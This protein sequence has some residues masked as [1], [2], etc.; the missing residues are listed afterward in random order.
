MAA[1]IA[2]TALAGVA[3]GAPHPAANIL[4]GPVPYTCTTRPT[5]PL[6]ENAMIH[7][8]DAARAAT[9]LGP[10]QLPRDFT[11]LTPDRQLL[12]LVNLDRSAYSVI[13]VHGLSSELD[14]AAQESVRSDTDPSAPN[15]FAAGVRGVAANWATGTNLL[16][17]YY[18]WMYE[19]GYPGGNVDCKAPSSSGCWGHRQNILSSGAE[20][21]FHDSGE[22]QERLVS[23]GVGSGWD[24]SGGQIYTL[25]V[26]HSASEAPAYYTWT[27]AMADGAGTFAYDPGPLQ[28]AVRLT[29]SLNGTGRGVV[30]SFQRLCA[31]TCSLSTGTG[32]TFELTATPSRGSVFVGWSGACSGTDACRLPAESDEAVT[33]TFARL[34]APRARLSAATISSRSRSARF[35]FGAQGD[36][37]AFQ[38]ALVRNP[39]GARGPWGRPRFSACRPPKTYTRLAP[40][41]YRFYV[42]ASGPGGVGGPA[43]RQFEIR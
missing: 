12:I 23:I 28:L 41:S 10:Y 11:A 4:M 30:S 24:S 3:V 35:G 15:E 9:G 1:S 16:S 42:R 19:D 31:K 39:G 13:P 40:D 6:C 5:S 36:A 2:L 21:G 8:L 14:A 37:G 26:V 17:A 25:L 38:C 27:E 22:E 29:V 7:Y 34:A 43:I 18:F 20:L 32:E 33:A